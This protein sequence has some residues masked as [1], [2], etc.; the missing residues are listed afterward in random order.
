MLC[1][2]SYLSFGLLF[3][4]DGAWIGTGAASNFFI[5]LLF[6]TQEWTPHILRFDFDTQS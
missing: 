2:N 3:N 1:I 4:K 5:F 6:F